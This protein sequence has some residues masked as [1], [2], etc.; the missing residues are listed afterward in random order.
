MA[1]ENF[2]KEFFL[3]TVDI[4]CKDQRE[5]EIWF[6]GLKSLTI[7]PQVLVDGG[8]EEEVR[9]RMGQLMT[10]QETLEISFKGKQTVVVKREG[11]IPSSPLPLTVLSTFRRH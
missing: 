3:K 2:L 1:N 7:E 11:I 10:S 4:I 5:Y 8:G 6:T 9:N